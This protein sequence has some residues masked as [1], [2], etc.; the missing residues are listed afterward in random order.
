VEGLWGQI[1]LRIC[2]CECPKV[3]K[4]LVLRRNSKNHR[5]IFGIRV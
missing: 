1:N 3:N 4:A 5:K 2:E